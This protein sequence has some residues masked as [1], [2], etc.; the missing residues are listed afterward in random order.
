MCSLPR[1][2]SSPQSTTV[3]R[4]RRTRT[5]RQTHRVSQLHLHAGR[6]H[7]Q[8]GE[9]PAPVPVGPPV[10][11]QPAGN[12]LKPPMTHTRAVYLP[13]VQGSISNANV[14]AQL[15]HLI[16]RDDDAVRCTARER[17]CTLLR[18]YMIWLHHAARLGNRKWSVSTQQPSQKR[19]CAACC[20][21]A[22][23][24][25]HGEARLQQ[26]RNRSSHRHYPHSV[27]W[28]FLSLGPSSS[29]EVRVVVIHDIKGS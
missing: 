26:W 23:Q 28:F 19:K 18:L 12:N 21:C 17:R 14:K 6:Q 24:F 10:E 11:Y 9:H 13:A 27:Y 29:A 22:R 4:F 3:S 1:K 2:V 8:P 15:T 7:Q 5:P 20:I 16:S 25:T